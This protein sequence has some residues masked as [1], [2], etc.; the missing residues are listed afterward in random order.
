MELRWYQR[1]AVDACW[2]AIRERKADPC[3]VLPTGAGKSVVIA[4]ICREARHKWNGR[5]VV[6]AHRKELL[7]QNA[8]KIAAML[9]NLDV[10]IYSAGLR[11]RE[12]EPDIVCAGIQSIHDKAY[13]LGERHLVIVDEAHLIN[14]AADSMYGTFLDDLQR[15]NPRCRVIGLTATPYR[16]GEG[17][18]T[19]GEEPI[20]SEICYEAPVA[21]LIRDGYLSRLVTAETTQVSMSGVAVRKGEFVMAQMGA[22][23]MADG[24][25]ER[26]VDEM[27]ARAQG[28]RS[29]LV[30]GTLVNHAYQI[31]GAL[32]DRDCGK[33][34]IITADTAPQIRQRVLERFR[35]GDVRW[36]VNCDLLTTGF[37]APGI[38]CVA[39]LRA[40]K[41][42]GLFA[43]MVGRGFRIADGKDD[44]LVLDFG[45]NLLRHGPL[46]DPYY[47]RVG[48][49]GGGGGGSDEDP[50]RDTKT[51]PRC[52]NEV[53]ILDEAC[54]NC[55]NRFTKER[56]VTHED[57]PEGKMPI[58]LAL[59]PAA[60]QKAFV[61]QWLT[62]DQVR[63]QPWRGKDGK[64]ATLRVDYLCSGGPNDVIGTNVSEW[65]CLLHTGYAGD[66]AMQ[67]WYEHSVSQEPNDI[68]KAIES[69]HLGKLRM[70]CRLL[71]QRDGRFWKIL[72]REFEEER[73]KPQQWQ[74]VVAVTPFDD[75]EEGF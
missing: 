21:Q 50:D 54:D 62:V 22:K 55:G 64:P 56:V 67:W 69:W 18:V 20:L 72:E 35:A 49:S 68:A 58:L 23:F 16:T 60:V 5:V 17:E 30:F 19:E 38:D 1:E 32:N 48:K 37:D 41:S 70:P 71:C 61:K 33:A 34:E 13:E 4:E 28:R 6:V 44:C 26:A 14:P 66:K 51:C 8:E 47:G 9:P 40:T 52:S 63:M 42:P 65:V 31:W 74:Q 39:V 57:T 75:D 2:Q 46:D 25:V 10:G 11:R 29:C 3:I 36:L 15:A 43:Q 7:Q 73:P 45:G 24:V 27:I 59:A 53:P 12:T